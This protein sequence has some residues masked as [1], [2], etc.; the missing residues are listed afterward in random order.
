VAAYCIHHYTFVFAHDLSHTQTQAF[1]QR[2]RRRHAGVTADYW[3]L[4][5]LLSRL[6]ESPEGRRV[7]RFFFGAPQEDDHAAWREAVALGTSE[8]STVQDVVGRLRALGSW[9]ARRD[10][11]FAYESHTWEGDQPQPPVTTGTVMSQI[12]LDETAGRR[13]DARVRDIGREEVTMPRVT[14]RFSPDEA[15]RQAH[16]AMQRAARNPAP[17]RL[18]EGFTV[19]YDDLPDLWADDGRL[20]APH[21][22]R[23]DP[24]LPPL[25]PKRIA[26]KVKTGGA[27]LVVDMVLQPSQLEDWRSAWRGSV[28]GFEVNFAVRPCGTRGEGYLQFRYELADGAS[29]REELIGVRAMLALQRPGQ[30]AVQDAAHPDATV[31]FELTEQPADEQ[32]RALAHLLDGIVAIEDYTG[33]RLPVPSIITAEDSRL[34]GSAA[35]LVRA[36]HFVGEIA[37]EYVL[38]EDHEIVMALSRPG[39]APEIQEDH[40]IELFGRTLWL[41]HLVYVIRDYEVS[42][43]AGSTCSVVLRPRTQEAR[44]VQ[45]VL[46][47]GRIEETAVPEGVRSVPARRS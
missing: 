15:G 10:D 19:S 18:T 1:D 26:L 41:G 20:D 45:G 35:G 4:S 21:E 23:M 42:R 33:Q 12:E 29:A 39:A 6:D 16:D 36:E 30:V 38:P 9:L 5:E 47:H 40:G 44:R 7:A 17:L 11:R 22:L 24:I 13:V 32:M 2:L 37:G 8:L 14:V 28:G 43:R 3:D 27:P 25:G 46:R 34:V 31:G